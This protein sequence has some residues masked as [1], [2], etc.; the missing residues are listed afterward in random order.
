MTTLPLLLERRAPAR[1]LH[2][3]LDDSGHEA[4]VAALAA[5]TGPQ[6]RALYEGAGL[7]PPWVELDPATF[8]PSWTC[9]RRWRRGSR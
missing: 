4:R 8:A 9:R 6:Q 7:S 3:F 1:D 2:Q 5:L